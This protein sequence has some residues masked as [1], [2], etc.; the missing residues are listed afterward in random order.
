MDS[1][2]EQAQAM[3]EREDMKFRSLFR[4]TTIKFNEVEPQS[5]STKQEFKERYNFK[6]LITDDTLRVGEDS[7]YDHSRPKE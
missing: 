1:D 3:R 2:D 4:F 7:R 5:V 6:H